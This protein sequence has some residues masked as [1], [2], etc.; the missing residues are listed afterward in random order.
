MGTKTAK[1]KDLKKVCDLSRKGIC[2]VVYK[3]GMTVKQIDPLRRN[4]VLCTETI[5]K[6]PCRHLKN[7]P[8]ATH[9]KIKSVKV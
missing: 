7:W 3:K 8:L 2:K 6:I 1:W 9:N 5:G 4:E